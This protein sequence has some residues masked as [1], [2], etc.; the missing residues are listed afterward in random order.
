MANGHTIHAETNANSILTN[1]DT[2]HNTSFVMKTLADGKYGHTTRALMDVV[3]AL[4]QC[5]TEEV[6]KLPKIVA[7]G[8]Q[9]AGKSSLIEAISEIKLPRS[10]GTCTRCPME[11]ILRQ[12]RSTEWVCNVSVQF[13]DHEDPHKRKPIPFSTPEK[14]EDVELHLRRVQLAILN[15]KEHEKFRNMSKE[16]CEKYEV[17]L[18]KKKQANSTENHENGNSE[19]EVEGVVRAKDPVNYTSELSFS[20]NCVIVDI[21]GAKVD[22]T[23]IDLPGLIQFNENVRFLS[24]R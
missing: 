20:E 19:N 10:T 21:T 13:K 8:N 3:N 7:I 1:G 15:P 6:L 24:T 16:E 22:V 4:R 11:V 17:A 2:A 9:S 23:F 14:S 18:K 5:G 12:G